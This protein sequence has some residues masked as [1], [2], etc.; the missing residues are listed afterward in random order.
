MTTATT[1]A[2]TTLHIEHPISDLPTWKAAFDRVAP[3]RERAGVLRH[4]VQQPVGEPHFI[5]V[6]LEFATTPE[7]EAFLAFLKT[8]I[9]AS[10]ENSP[11]LAGE[12]RTMLLECVEAS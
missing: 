11:A 2:T 3:Y 5:V 12:P 9:W 8:T 10:A 1:T 6:D 4:R 7:A